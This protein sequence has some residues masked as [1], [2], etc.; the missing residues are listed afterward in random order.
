[1]AI[2]ESMFILRFTHC[3]LIFSSYTLIF[4]RAHILAH[5][6]NTEKI[7]TTHTSSALHLTMKFFILIYMFLSCRAVESYQFMEFNSQINSRFLSSLLYIT[8]DKTIQF[9]LVEIAYSLCDIYH[10]QQMDKTQRHLQYSIQQ[11]CC[12]PV[13]L[14]FYCGVKIWNN[15]N[16]DLKQITDTN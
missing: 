14:L 15:L 11:N 16:E 3:F 8:L 5:S 13:H 9:M 2:Q 7:C 12:H 1:M 4:M 6:G 10:P